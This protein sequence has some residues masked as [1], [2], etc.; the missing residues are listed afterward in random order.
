M[1]KRGIAI[2]FAAAMLSAPAYAVVNFS[3]GIE[4]APPPPRVEV[5]P[6]MRPGFV[7]APGYWAWE[8]GRHVWIEGRWIEARRGEFWVPDRWVE[9]RDPRGA[10]WHMEPG[11]WEREHRHEYERGHDRDR[12]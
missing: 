6:P 10:H 11:H 5:M 2:F 8:R 1:I 3:F 4:V 12:H 7:W 9:Y